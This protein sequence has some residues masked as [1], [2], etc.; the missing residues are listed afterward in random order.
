MGFTF[1][2]RFIYLLFERQ[3]DRG[4]DRERSPI[5]WFTSQIFAIFRAGLAKARNWGNPSLSLTGIMDP[6][7]STILCYLPK[8]FSTKL[9]PLE[10]KLPLL[11][12]SQVVSSSDLT[13]CGILQAPVNLFF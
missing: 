8:L 2:L 1:F 7:N 5:C 12:G 13:T 10:L 9:E 3:S 6:S 11:D 4:G